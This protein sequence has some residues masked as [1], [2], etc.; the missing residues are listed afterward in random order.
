M[1]Y[2]RRLKPSTA[3]RPPHQ[4]HPV[5][6]ASY[7]Q[8][9]LHRGEGGKAGELERQATLQ[10]EHHCRDDTVDYW[11]RLRRS[12]AL[13]LF[14]G[15]SL[16][17]S[18]PFSPRV[19]QN[20]GTGKLGS[21]SVRLFYKGSTIAETTWRTTG[22]DS[23]HRQLSSSSSGHPKGLLENSEWKEEVGKLGSW[24]VR[25]QEKQRDKLSK[26]LGETQATDN[27]SPP[28]R[29]LPPDVVLHLHL[30]LH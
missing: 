27:C 14:L 21:W 1:N 20:K 19:T 30:R 5:D 12:T 3:P 28:P 6:V 26:L 29:D 10:L 23:G 25:L 17:I 24:S 4:Q 9:S 11:R 16:S 15:S 2:W 18:P 13:S 7:P 22:R 8:L